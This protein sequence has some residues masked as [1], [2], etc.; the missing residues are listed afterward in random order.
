MPKGH[1]PK[2]ETRKPKKK[3]DRKDVVA[4]TVFT[5]ADVEVVQKRRKS[6]DTDE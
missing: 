3:A 4:P 2:R 6:R 5:S 1:A